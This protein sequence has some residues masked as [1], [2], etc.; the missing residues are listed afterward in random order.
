[1][2]SQTPIGNKCVRFG[3]VV[4]DHGWHEHSVLNFSRIT[5]HRFT[6]CFEHTDLVVKIVRRPWGRL[7]IRRGS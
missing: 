4:R 7:P 5:P 3:L 2:R 6:V 1:M